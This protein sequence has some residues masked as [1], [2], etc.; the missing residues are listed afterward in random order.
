MS[1]TTTAVIAADA[2]SYPSRTSRQQRACERASRLAARGS[3]RCEDEFGDEFGSWLTVAESDTH[4][5]DRHGLSADRMPSYDLP[6][7]EHDCCF[8][9]HCQD[10]GYLEESSDCGAFAFSD[11]KVACADVLA[12]SP[13]VRSK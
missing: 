11:L 1:A 4:W 10:D 3:T 13:A 8:D 2:Y 5:Q 12:S 6:A 9:D 7:T